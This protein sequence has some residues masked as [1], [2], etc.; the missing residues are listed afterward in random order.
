MARQGGRRPSIWDAFAAI[1]GTIAGNG[2]ADVTVDE[3][4]RYKED[5]SIMKEMGFD[6]YRFSISW[7]RIFPDGTGKV[8]Q[9]GVDHYNRLID[10]MLQQDN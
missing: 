4:H 2:T 8:N 10:Y 5:V 9:E 6:A 7:W 1:P 3:Y